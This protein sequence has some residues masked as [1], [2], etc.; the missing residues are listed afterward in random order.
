MKYMR[1]PKV[2]LNCSLRALCEACSRREVV[3]LQLSALTQPSRG[4]GD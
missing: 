1:H 4:A 3:L 2:Q